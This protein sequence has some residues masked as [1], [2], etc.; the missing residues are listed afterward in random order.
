MNAPNRGSALLGLSIALG[1]VGLAVVAWS[2]AE[3]PRV[4]F[5][6][7]EGLKSVQR[8][9]FAAGRE[10]LMDPSRGFVAS[11]SSAG[12]VSPLS[13]WR[14]PFVQPCAGGVCSVW[15]NPVV[16]A[17]GVLE[18]FGGAPLAA[19]LAW[20][21]LLGWLLATAVLARRLGASGAA[22]AGGL[23]F[24]TPA[25]LYGVVFWEHAPA[26]AVVTAA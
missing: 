25:W 5:S 12:R 20:L 1:L 19:S 3:A 4:F 7:D 16:R 13:P 9:A 6:G 10:A 22:T 14:P 24:S 2:R 23:L 8:Q 15:R 11:P 18:R 26:A 17:G 21:G